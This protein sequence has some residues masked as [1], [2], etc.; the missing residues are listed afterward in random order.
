MEKSFDIIF[1]PSVSTSFVDPSSSTTGAQIFDYSSSRSLSTT[2]LPTLSIVSIINS[3]PFSVNACLDNENLRKC[4]P[5]S[6]EN[7]VYEDFICTEEEV[8]VDDLCRGFETL[9]KVLKTRGFVGAMHALC[10]LLCKARY[11]YRKKCRI[12][13]EFLPDKVNDLFYQLLRGCDTVS[14]EFVNSCLTYQY[15][16][17]FLL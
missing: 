10:P 3:Y 6:Q 11:Q 13:L 2:P 9:P 12:P 4:K 1:S 15:S 7:A 17:R 14:T 5:P 16:V 8:E